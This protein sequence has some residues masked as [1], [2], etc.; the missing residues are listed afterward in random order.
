MRY[1]KTFE[2]ATKEATK[3]SDLKNGDTVLYQ[4]SRYTVDEVTSILA[5]I[6]SIQTKRSI[7]I[8]QGQIDQ[9]GIRI[10]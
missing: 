2:S 10:V 8:N 7:K 3:L 6:T 1:I 5:T 9:F 4:G